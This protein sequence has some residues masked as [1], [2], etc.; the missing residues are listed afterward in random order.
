MMTRRQLL[1]GFGLAAGTAMLGSC[2]IYAKDAGSDGIGEFSAYFSDPIQKRKYPIADSHA[3]PKRP[4]NANELEQ[5]LKHLFE[6]KVVFQAVSAILKSQRT[7]MYEQLKKDI[8]SFTASNNDFSLRLAD[9]FATVVSHQGNYLAFIRSQEVTCKTPYNKEMHLCVEGMPYFEDSVLRPEEVIEPSLRNNAT[10]ILN[11]PYSIPTPIITYWIANGKDEDYIRKLMKY[12]I[13]VETFNSQNV[14]HMAASNGKA[15]AL[16][17]EF[18]KIKTASTDCHFSELGST[19]S[20]LGIAG[21]YVNDNLDFM[22]MDG[23]DII[24]TKKELAIISPGL[25]KNYCDLGTFFD[26][27]MKPRLKKLLSF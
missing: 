11:H 2:G 9:D 15:D 4:E 3:H 8:E 5:L 6:S 10:I 19:I 13:F 23:L 20:Q 24:N 1:K 18:N 26:V 27:M 7:W 12:D 21:F 22:H 17:K 25:Y 16:A 14:L